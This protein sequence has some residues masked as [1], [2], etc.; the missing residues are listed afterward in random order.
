MSQYTLATP[1][2]PEDYKCTPEQCDVEDKTALATFRDNRGVW[3]SWLN[4]DEHHA[5]WQVISS[6]V[7]HDVYFRTLAELAD[8]IP[9]AAFTIRWCRRLSS[10]AI[11][12]H[13]FSRSVA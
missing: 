12:P 6:M 3:L 5:I 7:W 11:S 10:P 2:V 4:T 13:G 8:K 1:V 9:T